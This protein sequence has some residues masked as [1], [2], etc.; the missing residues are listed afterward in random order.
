MR[1]QDFQIHSTK[2]LD[3]LLAI[4]CKMV[5]SKHGRDPEYWGMVGACVLGSGG[6]IAFG[7]NHTVDGGMR[8]HAEVVALKKYVG[9][10]GEEALDGAIVIT[11][12]SPC[13]TAIDQPGNRNCVDYIDSCGIK[14]VYCG[15]SDPTQDGTDNYAHKGFHVMETRN[16]ELREICQRMAESFLGKQD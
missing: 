16:G 4:C 7:V 2:K 3:R 10:Y 1:L 6:R 11:T 9:E 13:S 5:L 14:K 15:W 12:L 8:D